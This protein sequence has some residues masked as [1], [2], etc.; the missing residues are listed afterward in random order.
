MN[1]HSTSDDVVD[2]IFLALTTRTPAASPVISC[3]YTGAVP[4]YCAPMPRNPMPRLG[5]GIEAGLFSTLADAVTLNEA[6][7]D[8]AVMLGRELSNE[9][10]RVTG[11]SYRLFPPEAEVLPSINRGSAFHSSLMMSLVE[12]I[13]RVYLVTK[14]S[15]FRFET[16]LC[17]VLA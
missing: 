16:G 15:L 2:Q 1:L 10:Y 13:D 8:G 17:R 12:R 5:Q 4:P 11:W 3:L 14:A 6:I 7:H 9:P